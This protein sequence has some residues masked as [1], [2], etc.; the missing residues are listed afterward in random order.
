M[1]DSI[2]LKIV[3]RIVRYNKLNKL[4]PAKLFL[5]WNWAHAGNAPFDWDN[6]QTVNQKMQWLKL[7]DHK[8]IF[9]TFVDKYRAKIWLT[10]QFGDEHIIQTYAVYR[11]SKEIE[12]SK[13]P[14]TFVLKCNH[15]CGS[16]F[17]CFDKSSGEYYDKHMHK[18]S[19]DEVCAYLDEAVSKNCYYEAREWPYKN[20][21]PCIFAE[22]LLRRK[23]GSL[24]NDYKVFYIGEEPQFVYVSYDREGADDRCTYDVNW[25]RLPFVWV[26]PGVYNENINTSNVARPESLDDM[27]LYGAKVAK[28]FHCV[29][30][31]FYDVDGKMYF[32]E[33]TPYH[34]GG[35]SRFF[36]EKYEL[37]Y[38]EKIR[39]K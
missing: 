36:P 17:I 5:Q 10:E 22:E 16:V 27:L 8:K 32:G 34:S 9:S 20:V 4:I 3:N 37:I 35:Y 19:F 18:H 29:R 39:L 1:Y 14:N 25:Q 24:P 15:D 31:D 26:G 11:K 30:M 12:L 13:L 23:D 7:H 6:P 38:G 21:N 2:V 33:I 28:Y